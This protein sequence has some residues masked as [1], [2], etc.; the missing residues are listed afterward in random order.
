[1]PKFNNKYD[2][3]LLDLDGTVADTDELI[4]R[5]MNDLYDQYRNGRRTPIEEIYYFSGPPIRETLIKEFPDL[6]PDFMVNEFIRVSSLYYPICV[7]TF[8]HVLETLKCLKERGIKLGIVTSKGR[9]NTVQCLNLLKL[10]ELIDF[11]ISSSDVANLKPHPEGIFRCMEHFSIKD[12]EKVLYIGD[13]KGDFMTGRNA[14][15]D[16]GLVTWGPRKIDYSLT[17]DYW[18][19]DFK[20]LEEIANG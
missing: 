13:N 1:M 10:D 18:L 20:D 6:D 5:S 3:I 19:K 4:I 12:K 2:L 17:P 9:Q 14:G 11:F 8:P 16:V 15:V 7:N